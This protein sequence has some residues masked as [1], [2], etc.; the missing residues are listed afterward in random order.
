MKQDWIGYK[1]LAREF[2]CEPVQPFPVTSRIAKRH[3]TSTTD[4]NT[5]NSYLESARPKPTLSDHLAFALKRE[6]VHLEF[7]AR[8]FQVVPQTQIEE[9]INREP[10]GQY[11]R[12]TGFLYEWLTGRN[13]DFPGV[14]VGNY[15]DAIVETDYV[16]RTEPINV[17]RWRVRNNLPGS[18]EYCPTVRRTEPLRKLE[19]FALA[20][21]LHELES[22]FGTDILLRSAVWL[23]VRESRASFQIEREESETDRIKRFASVL[24]RRLGEGAD[25]LDS[26]FLSVIQGEI[27][28]TKALRLGPRR[29]PVFIGEFRFGTEVV[30]YVAPHYEQV[31]HMLAGLHEFAECTVGRNALIRAAVLSF[32]FVFIHPMTDGNGRISRFLVNDRLRRDGAAPAP[33]ILPISATI[34]RTVANRAGYDRT[35]ERY[36]KPLMERFSTDCTFGALMVCEDGVRTNFQFSGYL[37]AQPFWAYPDL[38]S[39]CEYLGEVIQETLESEMRQEARWLR[40]LGLAR[41][42][43]K[44]FLEAPDPEVDR[45]IRSVQENRAISGKLLREYPEFEDSDLAASIIAAVLGND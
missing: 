3:A 4:G 42:R 26:D 20:P 45:I 7:L 13:L 19:D 12:R 27:L 40:D 9:W 31:P 22:E 5:T 8:L 29:S 43:V 2:G 39:Q 16:T 21:K 1:W 41:A 35:L 18:R 32:G 11:A 37:E 14:P 10:T 44:E 17:P 38:T 30:H 25:P 15:V 36:S 34:T 24:E 33:Y 6:G 28:G 23:T